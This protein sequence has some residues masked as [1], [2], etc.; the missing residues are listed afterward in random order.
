ML[1]EGHRLRNQNRKTT[2]GV[3]TYVIYEIDKTLAVYFSVSTTG[4]HKN[5]W[6][7]VLYDGFQMANKSM[8][9]KLRDM[10]GFEG[11][12]ERKEEGLDGFALFSG[13]M[14][15]TSQAIL[16]ISIEH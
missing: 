12:N 10:G 14:T 5:K 2:T 1:Y 4:S 7:V 13:Y 3:F 6:N 9:D 16:S 15:D 8:Y 11:D